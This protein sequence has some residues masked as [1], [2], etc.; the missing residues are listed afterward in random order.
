M[1]CMR[2]LLVPPI[3]KNGQMS[4]CAPKHVTVLFQDGAEDA[5]AR[6]VTM[7]AAGKKKVRFTPFSINF[8]HDVYRANHRPLSLAWMLR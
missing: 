1:E 8:I 6:E 5:T 2:T 4:T 3:L 7:G